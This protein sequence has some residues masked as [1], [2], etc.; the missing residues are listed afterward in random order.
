MDVKVTKDVYEFGRAHGY[1]KCADRGGQIMEIPVD[2]SVRE[3]LTA[4]NLTMPI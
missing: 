1:V 2:F 4:I 3:V